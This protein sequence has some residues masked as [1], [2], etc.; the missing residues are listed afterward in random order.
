M[1]AMHHTYLLVCVLACAIAAAF[2]LRTGNIPNWLTLGLFALA[3]V[4]HA[5]IAVLHHSWKSG[6]LA[7]GSSLGAGIGAAVIPMALARSGGLG[8]GDVKLFAGIGAT[9]G[10]LASLYVQ[11]YAY[12]FGMVYALV[13]VWRQG[14]LK[15]TWENI[16]GLASAS[17]RAADA[18]DEATAARPRRH[19]GFTEVRFGPAI[20][21]GMCVA[22]WARWST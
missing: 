11:T 6:L 10:V 9:C 4:A 19:E 5:V 13:F 1:T 21:A 2:D 8:L 22:A 17:H 14:R 7:A 18:K 16:R 12:V 20:L 3:P 15:A